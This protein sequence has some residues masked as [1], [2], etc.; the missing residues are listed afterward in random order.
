MLFFAITKLVDQG[1]K[2]STVVPE[3]GKVEFQCLGLYYR[4]LL[5]VDQLV[6]S[7]YLDVSAVCPIC[8][9]L[10]LSLCRLY[11][12]IFIYIC[13]SVLFKKLDRESSLK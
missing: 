2:P 6:H 4:G 1:R 13:F 7:P 8:F 9:S 3:K 12:Y 10:S 5:L 11:I